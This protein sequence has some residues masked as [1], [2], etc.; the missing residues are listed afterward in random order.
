MIDRYRRT[1]QERRNPP[2]DPPE[3]PTPEQTAVLDEQMRFLFRLVADL[4]EEPREILVLRYL[5]GW[6]VKEI[7][8]HIGVT[9][10]SV[11]VTIHRTLARLRG[12][13]MEADA[14]VS[15]AAF[16]PPEES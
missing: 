11:S 7:A 16:A 12:K 1:S 5:L 3:D 4:P 9:E 2:D 15:D 8:A 13:W 6:Q 14:V 10:N